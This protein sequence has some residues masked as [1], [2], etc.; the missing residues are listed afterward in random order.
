MERKAFDS[1]VEATTKR[2]ADLLIAKGAEYAGDSD[3]LAN[4]KRNAERNGQTVLECWMTYW[5]KH[6]DSIHSYMARVQNRAT[7]LAIQKLVGRLPV[8]FTEADVKRIVHAK[9]LRLLIDE[10]VPIAMAEVDRE[11]SEPIEGRFDDNIN[12]S[13]LGQAIL[14]ELRWSNGDAHSS[15]TNTATKK[16]TQTS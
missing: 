1:L 6:I 14:A 16:E 13:Y 8:S 9:A 7:D 12:Y 3:R 10:A 11:L 15:A 5:N 2:T 4:F